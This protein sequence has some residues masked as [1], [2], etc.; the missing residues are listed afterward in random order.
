MKCATDSYTA[1][2]DHISLKCG[3]LKAWT[4][5]SAEG[6]ELLRKYHALGS[7]FSAMSQHDTP[8]QKELICQMIDVCGAPEIYLDWDGKY[9]SKEE[10]KKYVMTYGV[11]S[12]P[13]ATH[14]EHKEK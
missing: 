4:L 12:S 7:S 8:E 6:Q 10:A 11:K 2:D 1:K 14:G 13:P 9:V 5:N 3:T